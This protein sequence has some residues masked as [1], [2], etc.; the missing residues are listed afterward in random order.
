MSCRAR[1]RRQPSRPI[2]TEAQ[3]LEEGFAMMSEV[4]KPQAE[5]EMEA[6]GIRTMLVPEDTP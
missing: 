3:R 4:E 2:R 6:F 1:V 5:E